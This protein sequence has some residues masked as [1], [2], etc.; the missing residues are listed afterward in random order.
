MIEL[1]IEKKPQMGNMRMHWE[2]LGRLKKGFENLN[3][4]ILNDK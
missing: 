4:L 3:R 2:F 1:I